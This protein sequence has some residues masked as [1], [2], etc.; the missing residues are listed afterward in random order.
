[1]PLNVV[2]IGTGFGKYAVMPAFKYLGCHV[3]LVSPRDTEALNKALAEDCDLV[4]IHSPPF[5][6]LQ[7]VKI[8]LDHG[9]HIL[10]DKPFGRN[11][12][13]A[14][15]ML[16]LA[17]DAGIHHFLNFEFRCDPQR[18]KLKSLLESGVIGEPLHLVYST[19]LSHGRYM[20]H[21]WLFDKEL[22]G[23]W[24]GAFA[25]HIVDMLHWLFGEIE[26]VYAQTRIDARQHKGKDP[27]D[28]TLYQATAEDAV[29]AH[30]QMASGVTVNLDTSFAVAINR[31]PEII[32]YGSEGAI[33]LLPDRDVLLHRPGQEP[34]KINL[35]KSEELM[36]LSMQRWLAQVITAI[37][38]DQPLSPNFE[39]G[40]AVAKILD[41]MRA[42]VSGD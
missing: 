8:A 25:S 21:G 5:M 34:E 35:D 26:V 37:E 29:V 41:Q 23:G 30:F 42:G 4:S 3:Q 19:Q 17:Q 7:H 36:Q 27:S 28:K 24:I 9:C 40:L 16:T 14:Q 33:E 6:H 15:E 1:M 12:D 10:C 2:I 22:G 32:L 11:A 39:T 13:E 18:E 31:P 20:P 38:E